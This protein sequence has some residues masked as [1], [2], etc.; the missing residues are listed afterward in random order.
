MED[1]K[2]FQFLKKI[3]TEYLILIAVAI[4]A[5]IVFINLSG[6][7]NKTAETSDVVNE[8]VKNTEDKLK[9]CL[10]KVRGAGKVEVIIS[11]GSSMRTV[12]ATNAAAGDDNGSPIIVNGKPV[13]V[14]QAYPEITGVVIVA[15]GADNLSVKVD[16]L[17]AC[18]T[19]LS[20]TEDKIQVLS[21]KK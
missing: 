1:K 17:N 10:S 8:Y 19:F 5:A 9:N 12:Y 18:E 7:S 15:E 11:V 2:P 3:K 21:M 6:A 14:K 16:L 13:T 20:I 4:V